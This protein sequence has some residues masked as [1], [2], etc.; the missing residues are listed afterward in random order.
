MPKT[1]QDWAEIESL[2]NI[3]DLESRSAS[4]LEARG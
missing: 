2:E 3:H 1:V 4:P